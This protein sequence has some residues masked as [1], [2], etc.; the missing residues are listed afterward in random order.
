M[1]AQ[2]FV[3]AAVSN[4]IIATSEIRR[5]EVPSIVNLWGSCVSKGDTVAMLLGK[6]EILPAG[7]LNIEASADVIDLSRD[8]LVRNALVGKGDLR[9]PVAAVTTELQLHL[10]HEPA[11]PQLRN[12]IV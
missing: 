6:T 10:Q 5:L 2:R 8:G 1:P 9:I 4:D 11:I 7:N 3:V 12:G